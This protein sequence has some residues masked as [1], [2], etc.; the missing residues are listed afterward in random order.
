MAVEVATPRQR[1]FARFVAE[2]SDRVG[3]ATIAISALQAAGLASMPTGDDEEADRLVALADDLYRNAHSIRGAAG[4]LSIEP[5]REA[6]DILAELALHLSEQGAL[7][8]PAVWDLAGRACR[9]LTAMAGD[10][11]ASGALDQASL[12]APLATLRA[13]FEHRFAP[14]QDAADDFAEIA[15][16]L[17]LS[18]EDIAA[19]RFPTSSTAPASAAIVAGD[20]PLTSLPVAAATPPEDRVPAAGGARTG[21]LAA[22]VIP[23]VQPE[24]DQPAPNYPVPAPAE[25]TSPA[26]PGPAVPHHH[27]AYPDPAHGSP[28][29]P[30]DTVAD[31]EDDADD[32]RDEDSP[33]DHTAPSGMAMPPALPPPPPPR[34]AIIFCESSLR[35]LETIPVA[36]A[37]LRTDRWDLEAMRVARRVFHTIKGDARQVG[38]HDLAGLA[39]A[40]EDIFDAVFDARAAEP[41]QAYGIPEAA[42]PLLLRAHDE[43]LACIKHPAALVDGTATTDPALVAA[44]GH[45]AALVGGPL[46][47]P[48]PPERSA[49]EE[50]RKRLLPTFLAESRQIIDTLHAHVAAL[51]ADPLEIA[52]LLGGTRA[53][54]TLK[55]NAASMLFDAVATL[56]GAGEALFE[57]VAV[58]GEAISAVQLDLLG[59]LEAALRHL[60]DAADFG[61]T[62]GADS[63]APLLAALAT[64]QATTP[65]RG[66]I[67]QPVGRPADVP[68]PPAGRRYP[69]G[70]ARPSQAPTIPIGQPLFAAPS[71]SDPIR[72]RGDR[73]S[74]TE[75]LTAVALPE[76][77]RGIDLFGQLATLRTLVASTVERLEAPALESAR[78]TDRLR[79]VIDKLS[80]E[81]ETIRRERRAVAGRDGWD[82]LELETFDTYAQLMLELQEIVADQQAI[83]GNLSE[84]IRRAGQASEADRE[85]AT[86]LQKVLLGFR[87]VR[88]DT[89]EPRLDQVIAATARAVGKDVAWKLRGGKIAIDKAVLDAVQEPLLHLLRNAIDHGFEAREA[90]LAAGK[91][92]DGTLTVEAAYGTNCV[93][94]HVTDDGQGIDPEAIAA[95]AVRKGILDPA[96]VAGLDARAKIELIWQPGFSTADT[97]TEISGRGVGLDIVQS[98][99]ARVRGQVGVRS[100]VGQGTTFTLSVPLSL[101]MVRTLLLR[102][103]QAIVAAPIGQIE[104]LHL[105]RAA[106][107]TLFGH[108][109]SVL[110]EGRALQLFSEGLATA[111]PL[112]ERLSDEEMVVIE[113]RIANER[114]VGFVVDEVLGEEDTLVKAMPRYLQQHAAFVGCGVAGDGSPYAIID[115]PQFAAQIEAAR[116]ERPDLAPPIAR[117]R[118]IGQSGKPLVLVVDD[119][120]FMRR[121]LAE[122]YEGGGFRVLTAEDGEAA[123]ALISQTGLPDLL[124]L[125]MEMPRLNGLEMLAV[126]RQLPGGQHVPALMVTTRGQARH[127]LAALD[128]GVSHYFTKPFDD[129][130]LLAAARATCRAT[131]KAAAG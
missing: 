95:S 44:L 128:A 11:Q 42:Y 80:A 17:R 112:A 38:F 83:G 107:I 60:I 119:S 69:A 73:R 122:L 45:T 123:L 58:S 37:D 12:A 86:A 131:A 106:D 5:V 94:V 50:R 89:I 74:L 77:D 121:S 64:A 90:R 19:F 109:A 85:A 16:V 84:A 108:T 105:A 66:R 115:L 93:L 113:V 23:A 114:T 70:T 126:L 49:A 26:V 3:A 61:E 71:S 54:H 59:D 127:R 25:Q 129:A 21:D 32:D 7:G 100:V 28:A 20:A 4:T 39:E 104:G 8:D 9:Q 35:M 78:S 46:S 51:R 18:D 53:L 24:A 68:E 87:L 1:F 14:P 97:V 55:G 63:L 15:R 117:R 67:R 57:Q 34:V 118:T 116:A 22:G 33:V 10:L 82:A 30:A 41:E 91:P 6:S 98:A 40:G 110:V 62:A 88:L 92:A 125:D 101:S 29:R 52:P 130:E 43:L 56:T 47:L 120:L 27:P 111:L 48:A 124:S 31:R 13:D 96:A 79:R 103:G 72:S 36:L 102:D 76:I 2:L 81:F 99:L 75:H 65:A